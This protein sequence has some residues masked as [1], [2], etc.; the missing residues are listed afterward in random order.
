MSLVATAS[1]DVNAPQAIMFEAAVADAWFISIQCVSVPQL[2][3]AVGNVIATPFFFC[4][5]TAAGQFV[6]LFVTATLA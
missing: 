2:P 1:D 3:D 5:L 6:V 4:E